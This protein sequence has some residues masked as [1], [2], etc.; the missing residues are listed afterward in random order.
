M[1][2]TWFQNVPPKQMLL[3]AFQVNALHKCDTIHENLPSL[4]SG[5]RASATYLNDY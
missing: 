4:S 1:I 2:K 3:T 5:V